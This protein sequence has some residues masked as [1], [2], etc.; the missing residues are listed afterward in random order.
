MQIFYTHIKTRRHACVACAALRVFAHIFHIRMQLWLGPRS[1]G[2][3]G[4]ATLP[5]F[6]CAVLSPWG[7]TDGRT[8]GRML[9]T[10]PCAQRPCF[11]TS[12]PEVYALECKVTLEVHRGG[13][14][15]E[16]GERRFFPLPVPVLI[17]WGPIKSP[18]LFAA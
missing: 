12:L 6:H 15:V 13:L 18:L 8:E 9:M 4:F 7:R 3:T 11:D 14:V 5:I 17:Q 10:M 2:R 1:V 16:I